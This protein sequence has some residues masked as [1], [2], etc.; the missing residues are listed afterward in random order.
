MTR[1]QKK[2]LIR[3]IAAA[4]MTVLLF[5]IP[6]KG[7]P[8]LLLYMIPY[9]TVGGDILRK[10]ALG[11]IHGQLF[12]ENFLMA[13]ATVGAIVLA[14]TG[15]GDYTE[16]VAVMLFYQTGELF[17]SYAVGKSRRSVD[18]LMSIRPDTVNL[19]ADGKITQVPPESVPVGSLTV[20]YPGEKIAI[21]GI[22]AEGHSSLDTAALT[23]ES[24][25]RDVKEG[26]GVASGCVN[27]SGVLKIRTDRES[28]ESTV[29]KILA[30]MDDAG[31]KKSRPEKFISKFSRIYTPA[32]CISAL[33]LALLPP[34]ISLVAGGTADFSEWIYRAL[35]FLVISCPCALVISVPLTF[36]S[37]IGGA[38]KKGILIKGSGY[39]EAL[40]RADTVVFD[41]T[42]TLTHGVFEVTDIHSEKISKNQLLSLAASLEGYSSHPIAKSIVKAAE[43]ESIYPVSELKEMAGEGITGTVNGRLT[44]VGNPALM[45]S[46]GISLP[47]S[48]NSPRG[49]RVHVASD[50]EYLG[51]IDLSDKIKDTAASGITDLKGSGVRKTV[52]LT[53]DNRLTAEKIAEELGID[54]VR[55]ELLPRDKVANLEEIA[56]EKRGSLV[57][58]GDGIND[59]PALSRADVGIAMGGIGSDAAI[60]A[61]D[62]VI[63]DDDPGKVAMSLKIS[64]KCMSIVYQNI[65]FSVSVKLVCLL[66]GAVGIADLWP[67]IFADVGVMVIAVLNSMR[68]LL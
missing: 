44:A 13:V 45:E 3:I 19:E 43:K 42:G 68:A 16:A 11:I 66:L 40:S 2:L 26:D 33:L 32:V 27:L 12:D 31:K 56:E 48:A 5:F 24:L 65:I 64:K 54:Q 23:G 57:F 35:T 58:V 28:G 53:G 51:Y 7:I 59:A 61:A 8:R 6:S 14:L 1:K 10:A 21:D 17:Q 9:L 50:G 47:G 49:A 60:E 67:A 63:M 29:S 20:V 41:K 34:T 22:I 37:G 62:A 52:M 4:V 55:Y 36:F 18:A 38:G 25:P 15:S 30:L 39:L 46:L